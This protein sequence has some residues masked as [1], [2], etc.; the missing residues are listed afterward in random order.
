MPSASVQAV[1]LAAADDTVNNTDPHA[2]HL[3]LLRISISFANAR[4]P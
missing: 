2:E 1:A 3:H 4:R